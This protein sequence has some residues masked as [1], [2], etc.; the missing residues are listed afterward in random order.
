MALKDKIFAIWYSLFDK[1]SDPNKDVDGKGTLERYNEIIAEDYDDNIKPFIANAHDNLVVPKTMLDQY[2]PSKELDYGNNL[3]FLSVDNEMRKRILAYWHRYV[4]IKGTRK[5]YEVLLCMLGIT[6]TITELFY[7]GGF[8]SP[9]TF[10]SDTRPTFDSGK[11]SPCSSYE[12]ELTG[13]VLTVDIYKAIFSIVEWNEP[14]NAQ[15]L[16]LEYNGLDLLNIVYNWDYTTNVVGVSNPQFINSGAVLFWDFDGLVQIISNNPSF[17]YTA[18]GNKSNQAYFDDFTAISSIDLESEGVVGIL[19]LTPFTANTTYKLASN[20]DMTQVDFPTSAASIAEVNIR[21]TNLAALDFSPLSALGGIIDI[22]NNTSLATLTFNAAKSANPTTYL[23]VGRSQLVNIDLEPLLLGNFCEVYCVSSPNL[24][25]FSAATTV[26]ASTISVMEVRF[27]PSMTTLDV[28][29]LQGR[30]ATFNFSLN[31]SLTTINLGA[32]LRPSNSVVLGFGCTS[33]TTV[34]FSTMVIK[35][36]D[37]SDCTSLINLTHV[38]SPT[39]IPSYNLNGCSSLN[40]YSLVN[41]AGLLGLD[42]ATV[43]LADCG[44]AQADVD[45]F[46]ADFVTICI[47]N[48]GEVAPGSFVG[49]VV[50]IGGTNAAPS[51][52]GLASVAQL[53]SI[54]ITVNHS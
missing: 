4:A 24:L 25:T 12:L 48:R 37:M 35:S 54:G 7:Q 10:D 19:D 21:A 44:L 36:L 26:N 1:R 16:S 46:L 14:I 22:G 15:L 13:S 17:T 52:G 20:P 3:L 8:D 40:Y 5:G 11:C 27:N 30:I 38:A 2:I 41:L 34:D 49:R 45:N 28:S 42:N 29:N 33:L 9:T 47:T 39:S 18:S 51:A 50:E 23:D 43:D 32:V 31:A 53:N 6:A